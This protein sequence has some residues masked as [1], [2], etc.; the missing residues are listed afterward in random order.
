MNLY[1]NLIAFSFNIVFIFIINIIFY[2]S[3]FILIILYYLITKDFVNKNY[4]NKKGIDTIKNKLFLNR[5]KR[6]INRDKAFNIILILSILYSNSIRKRYK[7]VELYIERK[8]SFSIKA[9]FILFY[10]TILITINN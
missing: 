7:C 2:L 6:F 1:N 8:L 10:R 9:I 4:A 5:F 3:F